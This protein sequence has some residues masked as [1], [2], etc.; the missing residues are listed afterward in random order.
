[1]M[2]AGASCSWGDVVVAPGLLPLRGDGKGLGVAEL[3]GLVMGECLP[4]HPSPPSPSEPASALSPSRSRLATAC[5]ANRKAPLRARQCSSL[6]RI[7]SCLGMTSSSSRASHGLRW[8]RAVSRG[9]HSFRRFS[10]AGAVAVALVVPGL[11]VPVLELAPSTAA[12]AAEAAAEAEAGAGAVETADSVATPSP[13]P[14]PTG[15]PKAKEFD[16]LTE[17]RLK[18]QSV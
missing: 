13:P 5:L 9:V 10:H 15:G 6:R 14:A 12:P 11:L 8:A 16:E 18:L 1:M 3:G 4:L 2:Y 17:A 7:G